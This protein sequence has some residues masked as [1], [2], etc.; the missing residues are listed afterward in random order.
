MLFS[1]KTARPYD[2]YSTLSVSATVLNYSLF[3]REGFVSW[4]PMR[5]YSAAAYLKFYKCS[6]SSFQ[7]RMNTSHQVVCTRAFESNHQVVCMHVLESNHLVVCTHGVVSIGQ[8]LAPFHSS[9]GS[10]FV[11]CKASFG[12]FRCKSHYRK[13]GT[14]NFLK[15]LQHLQA[16]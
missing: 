15:L 9:F 8:L 1:A 2:A 10:C 12:N 5:W 6:L 16:F 3:Y 13:T 4:L 7:Y 11:S 14:V